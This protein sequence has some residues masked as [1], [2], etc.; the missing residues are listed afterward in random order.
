MKIAK[1]TVASFEYELKVDGQVYES[2]KGGET[3]HYLHGY[4]Q[5]IPGLESALE[6]R[7][8]GESFSV[9][10]AKA[11]AYG[12]RREDL[13]ITIPRDQLQL[14]EELKIGMEFAA[15]DDKGEHHFFSVVGIE[16]DQVTLDGN[17]PLVGKDLEFSVDIKDVREA[18]AEELQH[19]HVHAGEACGCGGS[20]GSH[21]EDCGDGNCNC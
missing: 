7:T 18:S 20:C 3:A 1:D 12:E 8:A 21:G 19:G 15:H 13:V 10:V 2:N 14:Q 11:D 9:E 16:G 5:L 6:N 4:N 17:H